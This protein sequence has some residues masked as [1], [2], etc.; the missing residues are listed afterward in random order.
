[1]RTRLTP[2]RMRAPWRAPGPAAPSPRGAAARQLSLSESRGM[3]DVAAYL[4]GTMLARA[5]AL[6]AALTAHALGDAPL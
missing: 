2:A 6:R 1:M 4:S 3:A 5:R